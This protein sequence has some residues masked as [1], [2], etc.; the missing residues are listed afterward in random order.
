MSNIIYN[1][2]KKAISQGLHEKAVSILSSS[3]SYLS[4]RQIKRLWWLGIKNDSSDLIEFLMTR[5]KFKWDECVDPSTNDNRA[6]QVASLVGAVKTIQILLADP[7]VNPCANNNYCIANACGEGYTEIV[8]ILLA[9]PRVD[10]S[11]R[12]DVAIR[13]ASKYGHVDIVKILLT[14]PRVDPSTCANTPIQLASM[15]GHAETVKVL[16]MDPRVDRNEV[17]DEVIR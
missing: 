17:R 5:S 2:I 15:N 10:P 12:N 13:C 6:I 1:S 16:L 7:R 4:K 9:D 14:D 11:V 8:K 3:E